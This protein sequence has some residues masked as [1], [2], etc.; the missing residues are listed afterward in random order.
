MIAKGEAKH[1]W[2]LELCQISI[3]IRAAEEIS[4]G[5]ADELAAAIFESR[6]T[7][8]AVDLVMLR[9]QRAVFERLR[10]ISAGRRFVL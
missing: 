10:V 7:R 5:A 8:G 4:T 3:K 2:M 1:L 9:G 6:G